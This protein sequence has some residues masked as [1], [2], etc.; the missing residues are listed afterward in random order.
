MKDNNSS[1]DESSIVRRTILQS[2][3]ALVSGAAISTPV[4][5]K[6]GAVEDGSNNRGDESDQHPD[7]M[8]INNSRTQGKVLLRYKQKNSE[9]TGEPNI[10]NELEVGTKG[11]N[12]HYDRS[13]EDPSE[14]PEKASEQARELINQ[15]ELNHSGQIIIE[16]EYKGSSDST[17]MNVS[18]K[19]GSPRGVTAV[20]DISHDGSVRATTGIGC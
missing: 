18:E 5:A 4:A 10:F 16:A 1:E 3:A 19:S 7:I 15:I 20:I 6:S 13:V 12:S 17:L 8:I 9:A 2:S 14:L 11:L